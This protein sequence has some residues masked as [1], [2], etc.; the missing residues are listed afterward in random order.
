MVGF[1]VFMV[2]NVSYEVSW[3]TPCGLVGGVH[4]WWGS[5]TATIFTL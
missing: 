3:I 1:P 2:V 5:H 4:S